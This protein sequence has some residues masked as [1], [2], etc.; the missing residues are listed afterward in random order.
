[1]TFVL[2]AS[3]TMSWFLSEESSAEAVRLRE[4]LTSERAIVPSL[5]LYE[6]AN[7]LTIA[8]RRGRLSTELVA[9]CAAIVASLPIDVSEPARDMTAVLDLASR[10]GLSAYDAA[11]LQLAITS[12][13]PLA[14]FDHRLAVAARAAG[15]LVTGA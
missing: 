8:A 2:D 4:R 3:V 6:V 1:M 7:A 12:D 14:T 11:Y 5:W 13:L 10:H 15:V 9:D